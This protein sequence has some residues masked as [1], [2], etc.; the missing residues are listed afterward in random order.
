MKDIKKKEGRTT[1]E[2]ISNWKVLPIS[3][4]EMNGLRKN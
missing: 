3:Q 4:Y 1:K 2:K